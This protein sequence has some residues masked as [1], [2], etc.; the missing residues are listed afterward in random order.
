MTFEE[1]RE[2]VN[3]TINEN[4]KREITGK[5][6]NLAL[7]ETLAAIEEFLANNKPEGAASETFF[8]PNM[9]TG[10][11]KPERQAHNAEVY[12]KFKA[13]F[14]SGKPLPLLSVDYAFQ[15]DSV[16]ESLG[17]PANAAGYVPCITV[18]F[19]PTD[20]PLAEQVGS[21]IAFVAISE[22][23]NSVQGL[24]TSDGNVVAAV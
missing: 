19:V 15:L 21:G 18:V 10:E 23:N 6:I 8:L 14:E 5:A 24:I 16:E 11:L 3:A 20:S 17:Q 13:A 7:L 12:N 2:M 22:T 4:G 9:S 1:I